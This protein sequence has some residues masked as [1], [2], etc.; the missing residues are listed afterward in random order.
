M[1]S[2][3]PEEL[4]RRNIVTRADQPTKML[5][6][7]SLY[8]VTA[9]ETF[10]RAVELADLPGFRA[11]QAGALAAGRHLGV[12]F[13][14]Y[15]EPAP[16]PADFSPSVGFDLPSETAW[17]R[18][19]PTGDLTVTTWQVPHGQG[20]ETT[21]AQVAADELG[22]PIE[23]VRIAYGDSAASPFT[24][25]GTGG[26]RSATMGAGAAIGATRM[27]REMVLR[28]AAHLL[29]ASEAD[30]EIVDGVV[31]VRGTR[32]ARCRSP[33]SRV[34]PG[35]PRRHCPTACARASRPR[36]T[37]SVPEAAWSQSTHCCFVEV[38]VE[39]GAVS[40]PGTSSSRT[41]AS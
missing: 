24:T 18:L 29:E 6:G 9:A 10:E 11:A 7:P 31:A 17:A 32:R 34:P 4:R 27:I 2:G 16:G 33:T 36:A 20:H 39:T 22:L 5:T 15:I 12:G 37:S 40:I 14:T 25:M 13:S 21:L 35:S 23:R 1:S 3:C 41:A 28:I 38:D 8:R 30:L 26:S 19:E